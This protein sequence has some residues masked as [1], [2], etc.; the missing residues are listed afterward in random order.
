MT[1]SDFTSFLRGFRDGVKY[2]A[3]IKKILRLR[4][5]DRRQ[6]NLLNLLHATETTTSTEPRDKIF[7]LL[8][9]IE[10]DPAVHISADYTMSPCEVYCMTIR[11]IYM[12]C[13]SDAKNDAIFWRP[14]RD[15]MA[16]G[17]QNCEGMKFDAIGFCDSREN[18][19]KILPWVLTKNELWVDGWWNQRRKRTRWR[20]PKRE[21][22]RRVPLR[23]RERSNR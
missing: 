13:P 5:G 18:C 17:H 6:R 7:A 20:V 23:E 4:D 8:G 2:L 19:L 16:A 12:D 1:W 22:G 11:A 9:L 3:P 15:P 14:H 21:R 10:N